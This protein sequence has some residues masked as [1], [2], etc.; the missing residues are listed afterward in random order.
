MYKITQVL[1]D[2]PGKFTCMVEFGGQPAQ[3]YEV[4]SL[5]SAAIDEVLK[6]TDEAVEA[7]L[8]KPEEK[9]IEVKDG[10]IVVSVS[11]PK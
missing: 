6:K 3:R 4:E 9:P 2:V 8:L 7:S 11:E 1:N 10:L 5:D